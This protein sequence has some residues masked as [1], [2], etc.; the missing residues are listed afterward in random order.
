MT[1]RPGR[2]P[3]AKPVL[4]PIRVKPHRKLLILFC[5]LFAAWIG[6][7][8]LLYFKTVYPL[9]HPAISP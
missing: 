2:E 9:R 8:L 3:S 6:L 4:V 7:L 5:L 1:A